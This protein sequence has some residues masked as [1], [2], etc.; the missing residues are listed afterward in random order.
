MTFRLTDDDL[1][2][3]EVGPVRPTC[4]P[5]RD[6]DHYR[7]PTAITEHGQGSFSSTFDCSCYASAVGMHADAVEESDAEFQEAR[8]RRS[9]PR[10]HRGP[11]DEYERWAGDDAKPYRGGWEY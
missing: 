11:F 4:N 6:G 10:G 1:T 5:C 7:C 9:L 8:E 3:N 2:F